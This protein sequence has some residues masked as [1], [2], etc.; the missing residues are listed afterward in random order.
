M[1]KVARN[2]GNGQSE[3]EEVL[4]VGCDIGS[5]WHAIAIMDEEG[6][7]LEKLRRVYVNRKGFEFLLGRINHWKERRGATRV[8]F[9]FE[10]TGHYWKTMVDFL[11]ARGIEV[12][13][14][15]TTAV[16]AMR[17]LTDSTPSK[18]DDR[19][20]VTLAQLLREGKRLKSRPAEGIYR[21]LRDLVRFRQRLVEAQ[22]AHLLRLRSIIDTFFP[23]LFKTFPDT[24]A[25]GLW[26]LLDQAPFPQDLLDK[27]LCWLTAHLKRWTRREKSAR[28]RAKSLMEA[29]ESS[30]GLA[31]GKGDR[32]RLTTLLA[33]LEAY[34]GQ[35]RL[36]EAQMDEV[37]EQTGYAEILLSFPGIG[38]TSA[39]TLLGELG[40]PANYENAKKWVSMAGIDPSENSSG[41]KE[42]RRR[43]SKKGRP[44]LRINLYFMAMSAVRH[45][46]ELKS[47]YMARKE[48]I[49][50]GRLDLVPN[51]LLFAV[52][53][54]QMRI[55]HAMVRDRMTYQPVYQ[56][57]RK[58]A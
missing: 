39:A 45:C 9:G 47:Y 3:K 30:V 21:E 15:K 57:L 6:E 40:D 29:A 46:P 12:F 25:V 58:A 37:L 56:E 55:L 44:L 13:F 38:Q 49:E 53:I 17:E 32:A 18:N 10:P 4:Y 51:Q 42:S 11:K 1:D 54:K 20:A 36:I 5:E 28:E 52:A 22:S 34:R 50:S 8:Q 19:D 7:I 43:I 35:I 14:I 23:E 33:L 31:P 26:K 24:T 41:K 27:G 16:K 2:I 48:D